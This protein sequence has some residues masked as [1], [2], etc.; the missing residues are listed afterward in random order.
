[1]FGKGGSGFM[2]M[3]IGT[4]QENVLIALEKLKQALN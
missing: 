2:R 1:M 4:T 3:N